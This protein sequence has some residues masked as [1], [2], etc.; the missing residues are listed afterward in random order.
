[1]GAFLSLLTLLPPVIQGVLTVIREVKKHGD[2]VE[3]K[4]VKGAVVQGLQDR[5][6]RHP[7]DGKSTH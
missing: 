4:E 6:V 2:L 7:Y 1:M 3:R 5:A